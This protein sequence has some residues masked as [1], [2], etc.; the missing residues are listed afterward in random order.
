MKL[1]RSSKNYLKGKEAA[2]RME[3]FD[4]KCIRLRG[5]S[6]R[7]YSKLTSL[8]RAFKKSKRSTARTKYGREASRGYWA[9]KYKDME[10]V[11]FERKLIR[12]VRRTYIEA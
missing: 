9:A 2:P 1:T 12:P 10:R 7:V 5:R 3:M 4:G 8:Q 11:M 6:L